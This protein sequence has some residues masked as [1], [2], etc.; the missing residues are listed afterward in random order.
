MDL[1]RFVEYMRIEPDIDSGPNSLTLL[2]RIGHENGRTVRPQW[3]IGSLSRFGLDIDTNEVIVDRLSF[4]LS[5]ITLRRY[6]GVMAVRKDLRYEPNLSLGDE[7][8]PMN[9]EIL[10]NANSDETG[11]SLV[12]DGSVVEFYMERPTSQ[13]TAGNIYLGKVINVLPGMQVHLSISGKKN[14]F[15]YVDDAFLP[16]E[17]QNNDVPSSERT[18]RG[19]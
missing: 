13:K 2:M 12:E 14:A 15:L 19:Q 4:T 1:R 17:L 5:E 7:H 6:P 11:R 3:V 8:T 18:G 10:I 9:R 16:P